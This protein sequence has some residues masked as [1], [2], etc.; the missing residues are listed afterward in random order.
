MFIAQNNKLENRK[1]ENKEKNN[2]IDRKT[3]ERLKLKS[4]KSE[5]EKLRRHKRSN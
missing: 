4:K 1:L 5:T 3:K 2:G